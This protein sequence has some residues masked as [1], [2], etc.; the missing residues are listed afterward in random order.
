M[1]FDVVGMRSA[2][3]ALSAAFESV[4]KFCAVSELIKIVLI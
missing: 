4:G 2:D 3:T 1:D